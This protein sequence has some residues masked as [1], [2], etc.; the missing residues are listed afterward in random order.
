M[1]AT[2]AIMLLLLS[3]CC[4]RPP[5]DVRQLPGR[6]PAFRI[7]CDT[8]RRCEW[9]AERLCGAAGFRILREG[10]ARTRFFILPPGVAFDG[11]WNTVMVIECRFPVPKG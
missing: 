1:K 10:R 5:V 4:H 7:G 6:P 9:M 8:I 11:E 2:V 3:A